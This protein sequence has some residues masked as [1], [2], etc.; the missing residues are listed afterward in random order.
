MFTVI[1][2]GLLLLLALQSLLAWFWLPPMRARGRRRRHGGY[3]RP[4]SPA[5]SSTS[6]RTVRAL[7]TSTGCRPV[8]LKPVDRVGRALHHRLSSGTASGSST[9]GR[10]AGTATAGFP[11]DLTQLD[12][13]A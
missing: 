12:S 5:S 10:F 9:S 7:P 1:V 3:V 11:G 4:L 6:P 8:G 2:A 13:A